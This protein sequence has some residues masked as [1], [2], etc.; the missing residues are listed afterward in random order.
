MPPVPPVF[1]TQA[2]SNDDWITPRYGSIMG[3]IHGTLT[4]NPAVWGNATYNN[5]VA[6]FISYAAWKS[7]WF[8]GGNF[9]IE[10]KFKPSFGLTNGIPSDS[11]YHCL[12]NFIAG[13]GQLFQILVDQSGGFIIQPNNSIQ[14]GFTT[15]MNWTAGVS[16]DLEIVIGVSGIGGGSETIQIYKDGVK[17]ASSTASFSCPQSGDGEADFLIYGH[18]T[19]GYFPMKIDLDDFRVYNY[20]KTDFTD[21]SKE[22]PWAPS[23]RILPPI[24]N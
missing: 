3:V 24:F 12:F 6:N 5:N 19:P 16:L 21:R 11:T 20:I 22:D 23:A 18:G 9:T 17:I 13:N 8:N 10:L 14:Y 2:G 4:Y 15:G 7:T 1:W